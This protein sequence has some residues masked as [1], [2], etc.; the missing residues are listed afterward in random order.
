M[1]CHP[2]GVEGGM[3]GLIQ[4][5]YKISILRQ[6]LCIL[7]EKQFPFEYNV[8]TF[9]VSQSIVFVAVLYRHCDKGKP[10]AMRGRKGKGLVSVDSVRE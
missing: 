2:F 7:L 8:K 3:P 5:Y 9:Y 10:S 1:R 4:R 6:A